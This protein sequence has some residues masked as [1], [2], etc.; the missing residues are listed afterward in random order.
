MKLALPLG[1]AGLVIAS[2]LAAPPVP[3]SAGP[4]DSY[5][6]GGVAVVK[7]AGEAAVLDDG[8]AVCVKSSAAPSLG[9]G[10]VAFG[11]SVSVV[12]AVQGTN[13]AFQVC[14]DNNGD[15]VCGSSGQP[16]ANDPCADDIFFSHDDRGNF[17][18]PL[19]V[20]GGFRTGC[21]GGPWQG[22]VVF[23]CTGVHN[24][25]SP[26]GL[27]GVPHAHVATTGSIA[28]GPLPG[29]GFGN[30]CNPGPTGPPKQYLLE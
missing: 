16:G 17:Y 21:T 23:L 20:P 18:N 25:G 15:G 4:A 3:A 11:A 28:S 14:I 2:L 19:K 30:F 12:D 5:A 22:Y 27:P 26:T 6:A 1:L 10:C 13:V 9:G 24:P 7:N 29:T 8:G